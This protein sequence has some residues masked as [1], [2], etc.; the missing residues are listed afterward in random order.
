MGHIQGRVREEPEAGIEYHRVMRNM[1]MDIGTRMCTIVID[2]DRDT[3]Y[4]HTRN[5]WKMRHG[6]EGEN[7]RNTFREAN[8]NADNQRTKGN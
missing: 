7:P 4:I 8:T 3:V 2:A 6:H 5:V 1:E